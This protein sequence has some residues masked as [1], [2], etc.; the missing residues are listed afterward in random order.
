MTIDTERRR[1]AM[2]GA[3]HC[4]MFLLFLVCAAAVC[5]SLLRVAGLEKSS[6]PEALLPALALVTTLFA[7]ARSLPAQ[8]VVA[9]TVGVLLI[10]TA[11]QIIG[12]KTGIP[13]GRYFYMESMGAQLFG[14]VPW[15]VPLLWTAVILNSRGVA[16]LIL[17]PWRKMEKYGL[18]VLGLACLLTVVFDAGLEPF[19]VARGWWIWRTPEGL[20]VWHTTPLVN[21]LGRAVTTL[22]TLLAVTP[23]LIN[24]KP[25]RLS[26]AEYHPLIVWTILNLLAAAGNAAHQFWWAAGLGLGATALAAIFAVRGGRW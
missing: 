9:A 18:W 26:P 25:S 15:P 20:P 5:A 16:R 23:W 3:I 13:F 17:R 14:V 6:W 12:V 21:F 22:I 1:H 2:A 10:S 11:A 4:C 8:N 19:A 7:L 24:K